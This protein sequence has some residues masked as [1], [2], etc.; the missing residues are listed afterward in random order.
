MPRHLDFTPL[1]I[2]YLVYY[3]GLFFLN[4]G[5]EIVMDGRVT[6][7]SGVAVVQIFLSLDP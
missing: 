4:K 5:V 6:S 3:K 2:F 1:L 7:H